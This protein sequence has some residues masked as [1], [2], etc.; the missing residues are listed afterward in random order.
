MR[1]RIHYEDGSTYSDLDG[2]H[3]EAPT[4]G[5]VGIAIKMGV[6]RGLIHGCDYYWWLNDE[7]YGCMDK[8]GAGLF[9]YLMRD[10]FEKYVLFGRTLSNEAWDAA[11]KRL[12]ADRLEA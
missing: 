3:C 10:G 5:V 4:R 8:Q 9:D 1:W 11:L 7:W 6:E 12:I 2:P